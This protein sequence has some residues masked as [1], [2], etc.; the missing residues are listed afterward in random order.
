MANPN[1]GSLNPNTLG[2]VLPGSGS[3]F[4]VTSL[5]IN[6][7]IIQHYRQTLT[8]AQILTLFATPVTLLPA[9]PANMAYIIEDVT[10][11]FLAGGTQFASGGVVTLQYNG[12]SAVANTLAA[13]IINSAS[14]SVTKRDG[15]DVTATVAAAITV[16]NA[17]GAFT[18][19]TGTLQ[20]DI[21]YRLV[22]A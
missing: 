7:R 12:G 6:A 4:S 1:A 13:A 2:S 5:D 21:T 17:T 14:S 3:S 11:V 9:P 18:T 15:I 19:G 20:I 16:S 10:F 8:A 22:G